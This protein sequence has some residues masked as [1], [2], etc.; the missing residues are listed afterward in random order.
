MVAEGQSRFQSIVRI[1]PTLPESHIHA[2]PSPV[3]RFVMQQEELVQLRED[4]ERLR[5]Q[6][7]VSG[8][9]LNLNRQLN[10]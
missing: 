2:P 6:L 7:S 1:C 10:N 3:C 5:H 9:F 8:E 4:N